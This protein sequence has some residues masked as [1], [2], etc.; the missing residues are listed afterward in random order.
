MDPIIFASLTLSLLVASVIDLRSQRIPNLLTIP[1]AMA[2]LAYHFLV[3]GPQGLW[4]SLAGL[5][6]GLGLMLAPFLFGVMGG[7]DVKLMAAVGAWVG[8][9]TVLVAFL[10]TS[11]AGGAYAL[12]VLARPSGLLRG[13]FTRLRAAL[14]ATCATGEFYYQP[15]STC[16]GPTCSG[17]ESAGLP[18]LCYGL[19]I[20]LGTLAAMTR[21][22]LTSGWLAG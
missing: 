12:V 9:Q 22:V 5:G 11:L 2:A 20:A 13:V 15:V 16:S 1:A 10:L 18:K 8:P 21:S 17:P 7:G 19:A 6:L 3:Q 4:F 14:Y